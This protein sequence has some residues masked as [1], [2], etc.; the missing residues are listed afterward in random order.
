MTDAAKRL[1]DFDFL[2]GGGDMGRRTRAF[3]WAATPLGPPGQ[4]PQGLKT[5]TRLL[6]GTQHPMFIW[7]GDE[8]IQFYNDAY[9]RSL[10]P[11]QH[12]SALGA[13]GRECWAHI[14]PIIGPQIEQVMDNRGSTW[15]E[16]QIV[17]IL[18]HGVLEDVCWTYS[19]SP[20]NE[21]TAGNGV[22]GV[23]VVCAETTEFVLEKQRH[24]ARAETMERRFATAVAERDVL[25]DVVEAT[26]D[27][28][29]V[30]DMD[31]RI[32]AANHAH[33]DSFERLFGMRPQ[34]GDHL[35]RILD[36]F[37]EAQARISKHWTRV[38]G[39]EDFAIREQYEDPQ[40]EQIIYDARFSAMRAPDGRQ[41]G[42]YVIA[43]DAT[44]QVMDEARLLE[45][46]DRIRQTQK[47]EALGQLTGGVAHDFNNLLTVVAGGLD[48]IDQPMP[49][50][51][52]QRM[53]GA[54]RQAVERG[55]GL[56]RQLLAFSRRQ[57]LRPEPIDLATQI[58]GMREL[59]ERSLRGDIE[60]SIR[61]AEDTWP[62][63]VD[64][65]ELELAILNLS[66][67]ARDAMPEGGKLVIEAN[68]TS[69]DER[70]ELPGDLVH[71]TI[72]D[73]GSGMSAEVLRRVFEPFFTTKGMGKG[74]GLGLAQ[75]YGF[76]RG[77]GGAIH[78][79]SRPGVGTTVAMIFP[80][81]HGIPTKRQAPCTFRYDQPPP[82]SQGIALVVEDDERVAA[83]AVEMVRQLGYDVLHVS[84]AEAA[85]GALAN[86]R[87][88]D[89]VFSDVMMPGSMNGVELARE[90]RLRQ[91]TLPVLL[92]SGYE[93]VI[94]A[95]D[96]ER[97]P[98]LRK[99]YGLEDLANALRLARG[100]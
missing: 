6:L 18:R 76:V 31:F 30:L 3:D 57:Q 26:D 58:G 80:R 32:L 48:M 99:P 17:P 88:V 53:L 66:V 77:S 64:A 21:V 12:P 59:L 9:A 68:N 83:L 35:L 14:W 8:L 47:I 93:S 84:S 43:R 91:P 13:R 62:I 81:T 7:W 23:L 39:G 78:V 5:A 65:G 2:I 46:E 50:E 41:L 36:A 61:V 60:V 70:A 95:E 38:L 29:Q 4:W 40:G 71:L 24:E 75:T 10:G 96:L 94:G 54:M 55:A 25:A 56:S 69:G 33:A 11:E 87:P 37:P 52:R 82:D 85:L 49:E 92:T 51:R 28:I 44:R 79:D 16:N 86:G 100:L 98:L 63:E 1:H 20:I 97:F 73:T 19:F 15:N 45:A 89:V 34:P 67:N 42:A 74:S 27:M 90:V 72:T 22:G